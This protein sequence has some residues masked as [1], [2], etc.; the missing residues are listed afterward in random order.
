MVGG[1]ALRDDS[2]IGGIDS[3]VAGF[4][5]GGTFVAVYDIQAGVVAGFYYRL[6]F[7]TCFDGA[8]NI[9]AGVVAVFVD[10]IDYIGITA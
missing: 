4:A 7:R 8:H 9:V 1:V 5:G 2:E 6:E 10:H 3:D